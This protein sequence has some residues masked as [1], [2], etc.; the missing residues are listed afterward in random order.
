MARNDN[1]RKIKKVDRTASL[2]TSS[3]ADDAEIAI[4]AI[5]QDSVKA[6]YSG[7][8]SLEQKSNAEM[9]KLR[10]K[11]IED[12]VNLDAKTK[13][14]YLKIVGKMSENYDEMQKV[15]TQKAGEGFGSTITDKLPS[16]DSITSVLAQANPLAGAAMKIVKGLMN[17]S[18]KRRA[19]ANEE[20][21]LK[22]QMLKD[23]EK[24]LLAEIDAK[25]LIGEETDSQINVL[26]SIRDGIASLRDEMEGSGTFF[27]DSKVLLQDSFQ[28]TTKERIELMDMI[29][30]VTSNEDSTDEDLQALKDLVNENLEDD[31]AKTLLDNI[32]NLMS[33][34]IE[35]TKEQNDALELQRVENQMEAKDN[36]LSMP[37]YSD[38]SG[39]A[40]KEGG[41][42]FGGILGAITTPLVGLMAMLGGVAALALPAVAV[43]AVLSGLYLFVDGFMNAGEI[44]KKNEKDLT[45]TDRV[46]AGMDNIAAQVLKGV[47]WL[48]ESAGMDLMDTEDRDG[49]SLASR[50][51]AN[52][53]KSQARIQEDYDSIGRGIDRVGE[54]VSEFSDSIVNIFDDVVGW[55][56]GLIDSI[57]KMAKDLKDKVV[58]L[59]TDVIP[60]SVTNSW[61]WLKDKGGDVL[62]AVSSTTG[63]N[64]QEFGRTVSAGEAKGAQ[65]SNT[66]GNGVLVNNTN[67][68]NSSVSN[69]SLIMPNSASNNEYHIM[70]GIG[71]LWGSK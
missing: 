46:N 62:E 34:Q 14:K 51:F 45:I 33:D 58:K 67:N 63:T 18:K 29:H 3:S 12:Q 13:E 17:S 37:D 50:L 20:A 52:Q 38:T 71:G 59:V 28:G 6:Q 16:I 42:L 54:W 41:G 22:V 21:S 11:L 44:A 9:I 60:D 47:D 68:Q 35:L 1:E 4:K 23:Q 27:R 56:S 43:G 40:D 32:N 48:F 61:E 19:Q 31:E 2:N 30:E 26:E 57:T 66:S 5:I 49:G 7:I 53:Q 24:A 39:K 8:K 70:R 36:A 65:S 69:N 15:D 64:S 10:Q 55:G 25:E